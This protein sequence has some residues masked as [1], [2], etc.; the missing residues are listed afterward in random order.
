MLDA[1]LRLAETLERPEAARALAPL[2]VR[3]LHVR[4]LTGPFGNRFRRLFV[5]GSQEAAIAEA[6]AWIAANF[7]E[8]LRIETLARRAG[9]APST[10]HRHFKAITTVS[11]LQYQKR[12]RLAVAQRLLVQENADVARAA[13][14]VGYESASQ[15]GREYKR[16]FGASPRRDVETLRAVFFPPAPLPLREDGAGQMARG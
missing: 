8:P 7:R 1:V 2:I 14:A 15:F 11:P 4:L 5:R 3:E 16:L 9:M 12:V 10:F 6:V 13:F